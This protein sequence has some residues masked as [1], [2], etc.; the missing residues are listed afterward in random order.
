MIRLESH[1]LGDLQYSFKLVYLLTNGSIS[2]Q[3]LIFV[4]MESQSS[5][6]IRMFFLLLLITAGKIMVN[7]I[8]LDTIFG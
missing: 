5:R 3:L 1:Q 8:L 7:N 2:K 6:L 4:S